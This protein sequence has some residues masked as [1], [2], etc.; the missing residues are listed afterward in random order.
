MITCLILIITIIGIVGKPWWFSD[1]ESTCNTGDS[2]LISGLRRSHGEGNGNPLQYP[3]PG[4]R[5]DREA[6][7][8]IVHGVTKESNMT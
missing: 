4:N 8:A 5:K 2:G 7:W 3:C 1:Q 6:W